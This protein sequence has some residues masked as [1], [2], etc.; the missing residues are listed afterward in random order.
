MPVN[1]RLQE[2]P[3]IQR[4]PQSQRDW[5][6]WINELAKWVGREIAKF[7]DS[8][9]LNDGTTLVNGLDEITGQLDSERNLKMA[10]V[11]NNPSVQDIVPISTEDGGATATI[12]VAAHVLKTPTGDVSYNAGAITGLRYGEWHVVYA[13]DAYDGGTVTY[14][15][16][17][18][19]TEVVGA[20]D[21]YYVGKIL[22]IGSGDVDQAQLTLAGYIP[23][24]SIYDGG[25][26]VVQVPPETPSAPPQG[27]GG[28][29][30]GGEFSDLRAEQ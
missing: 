14:V 15:A 1:S 19:L 18:D 30:W 3:I 28:G 6:Q 22:T 9:Y 26:I 27:G 25:D 24:T 20:I 10:M 13:D 12:N 8:I 16:T 17:E 7:G 4:M 23:G 2:T 21:R 11:G 5:N 29:A